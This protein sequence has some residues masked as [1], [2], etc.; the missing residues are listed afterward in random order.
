MSEEDVSETITAEFKDGRL[1]IVEVAP[2][3]KEEGNRQDGRQVSEFEGRPV[4]IQNE[5]ELKQYV[6]VVDES[7]NGLVHLDLL[8]L[9]F[10]RCG[11]G[12]NNEYQLVASDDVADEDENSADDQTMTCVLDSS[13]ANQSG[14]YVVVEGN[15]G[16]MLLQSNNGIAKEEQKPQTSAQAGPSCVEPPKQNL[17]PQLV[18]GSTPQEL[19]EKVK[20]IQ[21]LRTEMLT[22]S[23][24]P[25]GH[26][27]KRGR[28]RASEL[29][30]P[31]ELLASPKFKLYLY[32][33]KFCSFNCNAI[34]ELT[35][36]KAAEHAAGVSRWRTGD[37]RGLRATNLQC[38]RCPYRAT[39]QP[40]LMKHARERH[41]M[42][43]IFKETQKPAEN[44]IKNVCGSCGFETDSNKAFNDHIKENHTV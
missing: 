19:I 28:K 36:H 37:P 23:S 16:L 44:I 1:Q 13:K 29:P 4:E 31:H 27:K 34:K 26:L 15:A 17:T 33:C 6:E 20:V 9:T 40:Q 35:A 3:D 24:G 39:T 32:T 43:V 42:E 21:K 41:L 18:K 22:A 12:S 25:S 10:I 8:N 2:Y 30:P 11:D 5:N 7:G 14:P 38:A